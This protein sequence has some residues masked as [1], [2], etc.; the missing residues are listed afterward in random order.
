M[1][2]LLDIF[3]KFRESNLNEEQVCQVVGGAAGDTCN[4]H[5]CCKET[6]GGDTSTDDVCTGNTCDADDGADWCA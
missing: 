5:P 6:A 1:D 3:A 4:G 2:Q